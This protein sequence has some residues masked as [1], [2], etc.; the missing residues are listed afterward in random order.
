MQQARRLDEVLAIER[1]LRLRH[2][3]LRLVRPHEVVRRAAVRAA[4]IVVAKRAVGLVDA[5]HVL[6][7]LAE[8]RHLEVAIDPEHLTGIDHDVWHGGQLRIVFAD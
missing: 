2:E 8:G 3:Q 7:G 1:E 5:R 4:T 6:V